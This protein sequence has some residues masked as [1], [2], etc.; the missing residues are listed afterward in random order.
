MRYAVLGTGEVGRTLAGRLLELGHEVTLGSRSRD[1]PVAVEWATAAAGRVL[2]Q[3]GIRAARAV[4]MHLP[5]WI[6]LFG[7]FGYADFNIEV[8]QAG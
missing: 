5:L 4:E 6:T 2:N 3:G 1:N 7:R 8:R